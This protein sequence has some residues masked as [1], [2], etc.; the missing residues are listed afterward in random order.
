MK[1]RTE[2]PNITAKN[3]LTVGPGEYPCGNNLYLIVTTS[4]G[5]RWAFRYQRN[6]VV[7]K[8]GLGSAKPAGLKPSDAKDKAIDALRLLA[9]GTDPREHRDDQKRREGSRVFGEFAEEWR[10]TYETGLKHNAARNKLKRIVQVITKPLHRLRLDEIET[11]HIVA[12]L[13]KVWHQ[14]EVSRD[15]RQRVKKIL[16]AAIALNLRPKHNPADWDSRLKP[17][18]PKQRKRGAVRGSHKA[19]DYHDLPAFMRKLAATSDQS[20]RALEVAVLTFARTIEVQN[21][22]WLQLDLKDGLWDLGTLDTKNERLKRTPLP[23]QTLAYLREAYECRVS[24]D[25]V[26]LGRSLAK[27]ISNMTMLKHLKQISGDDTLTV[28]GFRSTFRTWAQEETDFEEEIVEHCLHHITDD[29]AE[30]A[31]K[32]GEA[33]RKRRVVMQAFADFATRPPKNNVKSMR[34]A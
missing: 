18:M 22:R 21:M 19:M 7:K 3:Y 25:F 15:T 1:L 34:A 11:Q 27:P 24:D 17:I 14:R 28:H 16:D 13:R 5:R 2:K 32:R 29:D 23:R 31:Y 4:G 8:M 10:Q 20:A 12:V 30:K 9:K 6:G 33:L 26:F